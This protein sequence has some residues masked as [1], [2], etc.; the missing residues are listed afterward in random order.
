[1]ER[2]RKRRGEESFEG[3]EKRRGRNERGEKFGR[4]SE[5]CWGQRREWE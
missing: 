3:E 4:A 5:R 2:R 1:M